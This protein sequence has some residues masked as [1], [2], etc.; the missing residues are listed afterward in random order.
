MY[1]LISVQSPWGRLICQFDFT[2]TDIH[3][4]FT[5]LHRYWAGCDLR[6]LIY[7]HRNPHLPCFRLTDFM[8]IA[9]TARPPLHH[10]CYS[11]ATNT[12]FYYFGVDAGIA[13]GLLLPILAL[14]KPYSQWQHLFEVCEHMWRIKIY[15]LYLLNYV[16]WDSTFPDF[17]SAVRL[18]LN[19]MLLSCCWG[20][21]ELRN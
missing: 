21:M 9:L 6:I 8:C 17:V 20:A 4:N 10:T 16:R 7:H 3:I 5:I 11:S 15:S 13:G 2:L 1:L 19:S 14:K 12:Y 18:F